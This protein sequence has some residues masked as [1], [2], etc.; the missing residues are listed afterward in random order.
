MSIRLRH[1]LLAALGV[2]AI[3]SFAVAADKVKA[4]AG[5]KGNWDSMIV[6][7][8]I[9]AGFYPKENLDVEMTWTRGGAETL[10]AVATGSVDF[11]LTNGVTGA[12]GAC[13]KGAPVRI[14]SAHF[15]GASDAYW[16]VK[17]DSSIR[18]MKDMEGRTMSYSRPGSSTHLISQALASEFNVKPKLVSTGGIPDT[19]TQVMSG[20]IDAGW[21][22]PPFNLDLV[23]EGKI[24]I[25]A[26]GS[27]VPSLANQT[28]RVNLANLKVLTEKRDVARRFMK[29]YWDSYE[30]IYRNPEP[31]IAFFAK[32]NGIPL[33]VAKETFTFYPK[34]SLAPAPIL[35]LQKT[36]DEALQYK[37]IDKPLSVKE[38]ESFIDMVYQPG[39]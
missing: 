38:A 3:A 29:A 16:Y 15:T 32:W 39:K 25:I 24:R 9:E 20:Q 34:A 18:S 37:N 17:A 21:A 27:D 36:L 13:A 8:G 4:A 22:V 19:R 33:E 28:I 26:R 11:A 2:A 7:Y 6:P 5:Q 23:A 12:I 10:Q 14:V 1:L 30:S 31:A 35:G